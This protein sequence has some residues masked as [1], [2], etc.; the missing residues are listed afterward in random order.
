MEGAGFSLIT[1]KRGAL[2]FPDHILIFLHQKDIPLEPSIQQYKILTTTSW[3]NAIYYAYPD[4]N[5]P[6]LEIFG[7]QQGEDFITL[8]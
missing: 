2:I 3:R 8:R 7:F 5:R 4:L 6:I 1:E